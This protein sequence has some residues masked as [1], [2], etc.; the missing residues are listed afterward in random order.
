MLAVVCKTRQGV[1]ALE[2]YDKQGLINRTSSLHG[3]GSSIWEARGW[4]LSGV[5]SSK[6]VVYAISEVI[7]LLISQL[8][9]TH[10]LIYSHFY[11]WVQS[12]CW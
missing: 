4:S 1:K 10:I 11:E 12:I 2:T 6:F 9:L 3:L 8:D 5:L 7:V